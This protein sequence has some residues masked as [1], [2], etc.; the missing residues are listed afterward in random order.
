VVARGVSP[1]AHLFI[2]AGRRDFYLAA[3][4]PHADQLHL[5]REE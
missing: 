2:S 4:A 1:S 3:K 5:V